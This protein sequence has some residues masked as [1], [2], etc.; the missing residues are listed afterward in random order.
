MNMYF[1]LS[2]DMVEGVEGRWKDGGRINF[3]NIVLIRLFIGYNCL[4][5]TQCGR[6]E[7]VEGQNYFF[8]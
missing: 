1:R 7:D 6:M 5:C 2:R 3:Y 4:V 8:Q